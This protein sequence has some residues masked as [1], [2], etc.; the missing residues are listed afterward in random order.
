MNKSAPLYIVPHHKHTAI[1]AAFESLQ[2]LA[3]RYPS[4]RFGMLTDGGKW[5]VFRIH[6]QDQQILPLPPVLPE[7]ERVA[8]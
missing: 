4:V 7:N 5:L 2:G 8:S 6:E 3:V 1:S